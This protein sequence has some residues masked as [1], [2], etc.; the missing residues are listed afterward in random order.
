M[1][2]TVRALILVDLQ[3]DFMPGGALAV[4]QGNQILPVI[5]A[6][7]QLPFDVVVATKDWHPAGHGSFAST[8]GKKAGE[9]IELDGIPQILWP[10]H[11]IQ[12]TEG[13]EFHSGW[14]SS[15]VE[16]IFHKGIEKN[17]DSYSTFFDNEN[18]RSTGL[19][20]YL[21]KHNVNKVYL[22]GLAT[23]YC[24]KYSVLDASQLGFETYVVIDGCRGVDLRPFDSESAVEEMKRV[25]HVIT[26]GEIG[27]VGFEPTTSS[28]RTKRASQAALRPENEI[29][30]VKKDKA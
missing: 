2:K 24:V 21:K 15:R 11:C 1:K 13:A 4:K 30:H 28:S 16:H 6:L 23:D 7:L 3:N 19:E 10:D 9:V 12:G 25:A 17:V 26:S 22:A 5:N 18:R 29:G 8:H 14:D 27:A 20:D